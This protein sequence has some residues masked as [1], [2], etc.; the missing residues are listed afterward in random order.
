MTDL[1]WGHSVSLG[2][3]KVWLLQDIRLFRGYCARI[4]HPFGLTE[5]TVLYSSLRIFNT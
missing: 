3:L 5:N 1:V 2:R 4:N